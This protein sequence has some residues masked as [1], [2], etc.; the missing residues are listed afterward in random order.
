MKRIIVFRFHKQPSICLERIQFL[1]RLNPAIEIFGLFGGNKEE[2]PTAERLLGSSVSSIYSVAQHSPFWKWRFSDL[3]FCEWFRNVGTNITFDVAHLIEW[4]LLLCQSLDRLYSHVPAAAVGLTAV[5]PV[6]DLGSQWLP[7]AQEPFSL[8]WKQLFSWAKE[9]H[10]YSAEPHACMGPG[11]CVPSAFLEAYSRLSMPE[12]SLDEL[13]LPLAS[14]LLDIPWTDT[15]LS[16]AWFFEGEHRIFNTIKKEVAPATVAK[17]LQ[18]PR[19]RRAF[20]PVTAPL[21][22]ISCLLAP[23]L[24]TKELC[25]VCA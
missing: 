16:R 7:T 1:K 21:A 9:V 23:E 18:Q 5:R 4:D 25:E 17:E 2:L 8:E 24:Q 12:M 20:H 10:S 15:R 22:E 19:G 13:R 14:Q 3:A 11:Y 6:K